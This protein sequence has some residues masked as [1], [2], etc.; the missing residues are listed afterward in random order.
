V[1][2]QKAV[3]LGIMYLPVYCI[4]P[5]RSVKVLSMPDNLLLIK[6]F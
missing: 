3:W 1:A 4:R 2:Q 5:A 6:Y